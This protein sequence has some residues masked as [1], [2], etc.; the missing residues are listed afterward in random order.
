MKPC[1][2]YF[3]IL[4]GLSN[5]VFAGDQLT[6]AERS[7]VSLLASLLDI[8]SAKIDSSS[9][10]E[11]KG[12]YQLQLYAT[13]IPGQ[14][15]QNNMVTAKL[16]GHAVSIVA[17][18]NTKIPDVGSQIT[19]TYTRTS[20][21]NAFDPVKNYNAVFS[22]DATAGLMLTDSNSELFTDNNYLK[23]Q[24]YTT[25]AI[26]SFNYS[27]TSIPGDPNASNLGWGM[28]QLSNPEYPKSNYWQRLTITRDEAAQAHTL[29]LRDLLAYRQSCR[30]KIEMTGQ[31]STD[32]ILQAGNLTVDLSSPYDPVVLALR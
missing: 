15:R 32:F 12:Q 13:G 28:S 22:F 4:L 1:R 24:P 18:L 19:T 26:A 9:C 29:F 11:M 16:P 31:N 3:I 2:F 6:D 23:S 8:V 14:R 20:E 17:Y 10:Y 7:T 21:Y 30:I 5:L 25:T 27:D